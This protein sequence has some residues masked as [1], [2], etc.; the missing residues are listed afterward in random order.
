MENPEVTVVIPV[1]NTAATLARCIDS[2]LAQSYDA[3]EVVIVDDGSPDGVGLI[4]DRYAANDDRVRV[5]H[6]ANAGLAEARRAGLR[7][8]R[9]RYV[10]HVDSDDTL[11]PDA[12]ATL[13]RLVTQGDL[14]M[15]YGCHRRV[16]G[17]TSS[18]VNHSVTG[19]LSG[20]EF[21]RLV[22]RHDNRCAS[23]GSISRREMWS[24]DIFPP[25]EPRLPSE[26]ILMLIRQ[27]HHL[28]RV[29]VFNEVVYNYYYNPASLSIAGPLCRQDLWVQFFDL[30]RA[31]LR[32]RGLLNALEPQVRAME[33]ERLAFQTAHLDTTDA[34]YR[35]VIRYLSAGFDRRTRV[36]Q[37]LLRWPWLLRRCIAANRRLKRLLGYNIGNRP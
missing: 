23:W 9:G 25:R 16:A 2:V 28:R 36:L 20:E 4:C 35:Q 14:D 6:Q 30:V 33:V 10:V 13:Y 15:A 22:M 26:D 18:V 17:D 3:M 31:D 27:S 1:Y 32:E 8:A 24:Y 12:V 29:G 21:L 19:I 11:P 34:W 37:R 7:A 5:I